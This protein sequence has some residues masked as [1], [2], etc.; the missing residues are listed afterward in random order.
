MSDY[1][2]TAFQESAE[3][4]VAA[5]LKE[6]HRS[7]DEREVLRGTIPFH[8]R[9]PQ[10]ALRLKAGDLEVFLFDDEASYA[11]PHRK[12]GLERADFNSTDELIVALMEHLR[13]D[14]STR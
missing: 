4:A 12:T 11:T 2:L 9:D 7:V 3:R 10:T 6:H 5:L 8:S 1:K 14:M 13:A